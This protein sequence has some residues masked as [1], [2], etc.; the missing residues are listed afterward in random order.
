MVQRR[1][2]FIRVD[3]EKRGTVYVK[4]DG[5]RRITIKKY[6]DVLIKVEFVDMPVEKKIKD[7]NGK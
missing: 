1:N 2:S 7:K 6:D 3:D 4:V 5:N